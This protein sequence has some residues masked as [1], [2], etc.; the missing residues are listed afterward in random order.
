MER[1]KGG[2]C[3]KSR[4]SNING[5]PG[6]SKRGLQASSMGTACLLE[7]QGLAS[8]TRPTESEPVS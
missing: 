2:L 8:H 4:L 3:R 5:H 6:Y 1:G 7:M